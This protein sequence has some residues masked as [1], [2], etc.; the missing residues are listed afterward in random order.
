MLNT[1]MSIG[2]YSQEKAQ[3]KYARKIQEYKNK[4]TNIAD[5][6]NQNVITQNT[7]LQIQQSAQKAVFMRSDALGAIGSAT[8]S[9]GAA[10]VKGRSVNAA[11]TDISRKA[12]LLEK[13]RAQD[14]EQ[15]FM[16]ADQQRLSSSLSAVQGQDLSYIQQPSFGLALLAGINQD[17]AQAAQAAG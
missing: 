16:Q 4:M 10:G 17:I 9:A 12:G 11:L 15:Y 5:A 14:L 1:L 7:T 13:Q 8:A 6:I 3:A 2:R